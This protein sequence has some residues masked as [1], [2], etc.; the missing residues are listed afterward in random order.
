VSQASSKG[1]SEETRYRGVRWRRSASGT[2]TWYNDGNRRWVRW[3]EGAD[4]PPVPVQWATAGPAQADAAAGPATAPIP[5]PRTRVGARP[6][7]SGPVPRPS[8]RSPY[9]LVPIAIAVFAVAIG[10]WEGFHPRHATTS[11]VS[12]ARALIGQCLARDGGSATAPRFHDAPISCASAGAAVKVVGV[13]VPGQSGSS[14]PSG[15]EV[16]ALVD[17]GVSGAPLECVVKV[18]TR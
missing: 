16:L 18:P 2:L 3:Y 12:K 14:C 1:R 4:A 17:P 11:D 13:I 5:T 6:A 10:A 8:L 9:R 15:S 7:E